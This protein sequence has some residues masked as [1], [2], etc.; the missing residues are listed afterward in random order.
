MSNLKVFWRGFKEGSKRFSHVITGIINF[1]LLFLVYFVGVGVTSI[2]DKIFRKHFLNIKL[3]K[4]TISYWGP[5]NLSKKPIEE[6][7]RQF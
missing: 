6:Y 2:F 7:Y 3:K 5:L 1:V 4:D